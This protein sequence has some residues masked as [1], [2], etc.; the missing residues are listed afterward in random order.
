MLDWP[1]SSPQKTTML[2]FFSAAAGFGF[3]CACAAHA[4]P[5]AAMNR[6]S[7]RVMAIPSLLKCENFLPVGFHA[8][9]D[10]VLRL[11]LVPG[12]VEL[13]DV[14]G[15]IVGVFARGIVVMHEQ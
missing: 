7:L 11:R 5:K 10:P 2:G 6:M 14:R 4:R 3:C 1:M 8:D 13:T 15:T 9:D 12:L